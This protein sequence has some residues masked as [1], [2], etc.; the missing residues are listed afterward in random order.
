MLGDECWKALLHD[1]DL[2]FPSG[3]GVRILLSFHQIIAKLFFIGMHWRQFAAS[4][5]T[6]TLKLEA[7]E[8]DVST[9]AVLSF[10]EAAMSN[11]NLQ[12][13]SPTSRHTNVSD[14]PTA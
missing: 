10:L 7:P 11:V 9:E 5:P 3:G 4:L 13:L 2:P 12:G 14:P 1:V 8:P 6:H